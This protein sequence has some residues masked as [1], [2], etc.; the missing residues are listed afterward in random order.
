MAAKSISPQNPPKIENLSSPSSPLPS[1]LG[2]SFAVFLGLL[3]HSAVTHLS[4]LQSRNRI[5]SLKLFQAED[6]LRTLRS[7][8]K[9][10]SKANARVV[11]IFA[12]HRQAW[13]Q[14]ERRLLNRIEESSAEIERMRGRIGELEGE[15]ERLEREVR[16]RDEMLDFVT[17][18]DDCDEGDEDE[19]QRMF[20]DFDGVRVSDLDR[21]RGGEEILPP[22]PPP[23]LMG[24]S[25]SKRWMTE[26][27]MNGW[28]VKFC[29]LTLFVFL[30]F[31]KKKCLK[32]NIL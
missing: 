2:L 16:E 29:F 6:Q 26:G 13:Q 30:L 21:N 3:P 31:L 28:Q 15:V 17:R 11:E 9:E 7:R 8:R 20:G 14:E 18:K 10:D 24:G 27:S 12:S 19:K 22:P 4:S 5:L 23:P 25:D 1:Y 32:W